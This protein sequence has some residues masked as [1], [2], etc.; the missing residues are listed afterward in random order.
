[1]SQQTHAH[2]TLRRKLT[3]VLLLI[4]AAVL[5][6]S[7]TA[8]IITFS[9]NAKQDF[10]Q[11]LVTLADIVGK[12][13]SAAMLFSDTQAAQETL[14]SLSNKPQLI[15]AWAITNDRHVLASYTRYKTSAGSIPTDEQISSQ[16][17]LLMLF[18]PATI[19]KS[20][21]VLEGGRELGVVVISADSSGFYNKLLIVAVAAITAFVIALGLA[22]LLSFYMN[23]HITAPI[24]SLAATMQLVSDTKNY[25][26]RVSTEAS[27]AEVGQLIDGFNEML[28]VIEKQ[29][30]MVAWYN[31]N[32]EQQIETRTRLLAETNKDLET[33]ISELQLAKEAAEAANQA[34][35][36]FLANMSHEVRTPMN[37]V[38]GM[39]ELLATTQLT[40]KQRGFV[41]TIR[42]SADSLLNIV[43]DILDFSKIEAGRMGL[44]RINFDPCTVIE[45]V[46][47]LFAAYA[48]SKGLELV[49]YLD[50]TIP[51][52]A[53]G[54][55]E[56]FKQILVNLLS[57]ALKFTG[58]GEVSIEASAADK[59]GDG[60]GLTVKVHDTGIGI[61]PDKLQT[62]FDTFT[63]A[64]GSTTRK[65]G[66]TGLG[67]S[68]ARQ[69]AVMM[70]GDI[71]VTSE[72]GQGSTFTLSVTFG[73]CALPPV[74]T[75]Q[76]VSLLQG[77]RVLVADD[78][79]TNRKTLCNYLSS[80]GMKPETA[81]SGTEV[82]ALLELA[83]KSNP[84][85]IVILDSRLPDMNVRQFATA[86]RKQPHLN[87]LKLLILT[88]PGSEETTAHA[89]MS[90]SATY[91]GKPVRR[92]Q[93]YKS[94]G[95]M[96][97]GVVSDNH[98]D[99]AS[100]RHEET[101]SFNA[102]IL[103][104]EDTRVNQD[105]VLAML[106]N[107]GC[108]CDVATN[109]IDALTKLAD[110]SYDMVLMDCQMPGLD[111]YETTRR[112]RQ[113]EKEHSKPYTK[114]IALTAH[115][116]VEDRQKCLAAGMDDYLAKPFT[117]SQLCLLLQQYMPDS[118]CIS[119]TEQLG[120]L[121]APSPAGQVLDM[122]C[123]A[124]ICALQRPG[125]TS[126]LD[127]VIT[128]FGVDARQ[129]LLALPDAITAEDL[130]KVRDLAHKFKSAAAN[131]GAVR[132]AAHCKEM[133][134]Q[135]GAGLTERLP[136]LCATIEIEYAAAW[137]K[138]R[139][140]LANELHERMQVS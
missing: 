31:Q 32:L 69:L 109:G 86:I 132:L 113:F 120:A 97:N 60:W 4:S 116:L 7:T 101:V 67:L 57:N 135:A 112:L 52:Y 83:A 59:Q 61:T 111:G 102:S 103:L 128:H 94:I 119:P 15:A 85:S 96:L 63:Q 64:D 11:E 134:L 76:S 16:R 38:L 95:N 48:H 28:S 90:P 46:T 71:T 133:E 138:L 131:L 54:D 51:A 73:R 56:R 30:A 136:A 77:V 125:T 105:V 74:Q 50:N 44:N 3:M 20:S 41:Q 118:Y 25:A 34:K 36:Q 49:V 37:G 24:A 6:I 107:L 81:G 91:L 8:F 55:P 114:V 2:A 122:T 123:I 62:I 68:I 126:L 139:L 88:P 98:E 5:F 18:P 121:P 33:T 137:D 106:E 29:N 58:T 100:T 130:E 99:D 92:S 14:R 79:D 35:S 65:F 17:Y 43:N 70:G 82:L 127:K 104:V 108:R 19:Y 1:M 22:Y 10:D 42:T 23:R 13:I 93:L 129:L 72:S 124:A 110:H 117:L 40:P 45:E 115:A 84:F 140:L 66:G 39:V 47:E 26:H 75:S 89:R 80:W 12:N 9:F 27:T 78:N 53:I 87:A 21:Q